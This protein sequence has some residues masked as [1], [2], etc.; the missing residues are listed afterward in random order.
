[1]AAFA[2]RLHLDFM[3]G[4]FVETKSPLLSEVWRPEVDALDIHLMYK[5]P[6][7]EIAAA[8]KLNPS[9]I[10]IHAEAVAAD[11][12]RDMS[13]EIRK[14]GV[15]FGVALLPTT[16]ASYLIP[17]TSYLDY[18]LVFSGSLGHYG[19]HADLSL[20]SK[21]RE[22][23]DKKPTIEIGL[24]GCINDQNSRQLVDSGVDVLNVGGFIQRAENPAEA[25]AKLQRLIN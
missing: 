13:N 20:L 8:L 4:E 5:N 11:E 22:I 7:I 21:V 2:K 17:H 18:V 3:D 10:I 14:N 23:K 6:V 9:L 19:G 12:L 1:M 16:P 24:Y 25:Y 15:K